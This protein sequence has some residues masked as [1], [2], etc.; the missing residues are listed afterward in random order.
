V[1]LCVNFCFFFYRSETL[2]DTSAYQRHMSDNKRIK[3]CNRL[4]PC[5]KRA[6]VIAIK[7]Y[8]CFA[9]KRF[10]VALRFS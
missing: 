8:I 1:E 7:R 9:K 10:K 5:V 3:R 6:L 2:I 4:E